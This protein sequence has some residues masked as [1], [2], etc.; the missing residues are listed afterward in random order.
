MPSARALLVRIATVVVA[1]ALAPLAW[2]QGMTPP[3]REALNAAETWLARVD[4][5][6]YADAWTAAAE[7]FRSSVTRQ[8]FVEGAPKLRKDLG[9]VASRTGEK[10]AYVG[11]PPD[12]SDPTGAAK[13]GMKIAIHFDTRFAGNKKATEEVTMLLES[14]GVW[15]P[16]GYYIQ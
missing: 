15:R 2:A 13:P 1:T 3:Q 16:V 6:Q 8:S 11:A 14:D 10:L 12:P 7:P 9:K 5:Q 4:K